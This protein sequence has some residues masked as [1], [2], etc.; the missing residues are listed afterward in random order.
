MASNFPPT[1]TLEW[2]KVTWGGHKWTGQLCKNRF[3]KHIRLKP[4][5]ILTK[6]PYIQWFHLLLLWYTVTTLVVT[7]THSSVSPPFVPPVFFLP[8]LYHSFL[9]FVHFSRTFLSSSFHSKIHFLLRILHPSF[10]PSLSDSTYCALT[11]PQ[12]LLSKWWN[13]FTPTQTATS[14]WTMPR[15]LFWG[16]QICVFTACCCASEQPHK[17]PHCSSL[18]PV[19]FFHLHHNTTT[20]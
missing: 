6:R 12:T 17:L 4:L 16:L 15:L 8:P 20:C 1:Q 10:I 7:D 5:T 19:D 14:W 9:L 2:I 3:V 18:K 11:H 13:A